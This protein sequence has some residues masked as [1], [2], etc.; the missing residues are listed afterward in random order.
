MTTFVDRL[1]TA[2]D[3]TQ[4]LVCVGLDVDDGRVRD[5]VV[6]ATGARRDRVTVRFNRDIVDATADL[7]CAYKFSM[8]FYE[9]Q[10]LAGL[11]ALDKTIKYIRKAAPHAIIIGDN[12]LGDIG[13]TASAYAKAMFGVL[14]FD[15]V[16]INAWGGHDTVEPWL[17]YKDRCSFI[18]CRGSNPGSAEFQDLKVFN[19]GSKEE[20][21]YLRMARRSR[22]WNKDRNLGLVAGATAPEQLAAIREVCPDMPLLIPGVGA[23]GGDLEASVRYGVDAVGRNAII[24]SSRDIIYA[25]S[26]ADYAEAARLATMQ[27]RDAINATLD[28]MGLGWQ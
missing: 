3:A 2:C 5:A 9:A 17:A 18:W 24:S 13:S 12:K 23:Q 14:K 21:L 19:P 7:T 1:N 22:D 8:A 25:S 10:K 20:F 16:T 28:D 26:G 15:A 27:L 4:S 11:I 6:G